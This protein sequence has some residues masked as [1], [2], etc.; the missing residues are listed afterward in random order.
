MPTNL[1]KREKQAIDYITA[2]GYELNAYSISFDVTR[3]RVKALI[4]YNRSEMQ[5][6]AK[7]LA[8]DKANGCCTAPKAPAPPVRAPVLTPVMLARVVDAAAR[9]APV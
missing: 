4:Y 2:C 1:T 8:A 5:M 7:E 3:A 9:A 6:M